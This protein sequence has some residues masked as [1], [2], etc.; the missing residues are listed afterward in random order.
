MGCS[1]NAYL[2]WGYAWDE[3][4]EEAFVDVLY[5][6]HDEEGYEWP[7]DGDGDDPS[8]YDLLEDLPSTVEWGTHCH[9]DHSM[10]FIC[11]AESHVHA[12]R[13]YP[14][15]I[16]QEHFEQGTVKAWTKILHDALAEIG[17]EPPGEPGW[18]IASYTD[19]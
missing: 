18:F 10:P 6:G 2:G 3:T 12:Y 14:Q 19:Y 17:V 11:I 9:G 16:S 8:W 13:G 4:C 15:D 7:D 5:P 1:T